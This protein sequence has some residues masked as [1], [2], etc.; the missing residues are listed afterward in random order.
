M[1]RLAR[2]PAFT[3]ASASCNPRAAPHPSASNQCSRKHASSLSPAAAAFIAATAN[4]R[5]AGLLDNRAM[6]VLSNYLHVQYFAGK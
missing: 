5:A 2:Y 1:R 6:L 3:A 4:H